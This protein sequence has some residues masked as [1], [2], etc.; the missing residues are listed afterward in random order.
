[1]LRKLRKAHAGLLAGLFS[2]ALMAGCASAPVEEST[3]FYDYDPES[4]LLTGTLDHAVRPLALQAVVTPPEQTAYPTVIVK[5]PVLS[6][7]EID[8]WIQAFFGDSGAQAEVAG[9]S[10][11]VDDSDT[12]HC[13]ATP[14]GQSFSYSEYD[15]RLGYF[16]IGTSLTRELGLKQYTVQEEPDTQALAD[17]QDAA[18]ALLEELGLTEFVL[19]ST[20]ALAL[21]SGPVCYALLYSHEIAGL[22]TTYDSYPIPGTYQYYNGDN[23]YI[24]VI[25]GAVVYLTGFIREVVEVEVSRE[26]IG[27]EAAMGALEKNSAYISLT[28]DVDI[29]IENISLRYAPA[30]APLEEDSGAYRLYPAWHFGPKYTNVYSTGQNLLDINAYDGSVLG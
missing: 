26:I 25:D 4:G 5:P 16:H 14:D 28:T 9:Q 6:D 10:P 1:M 27:L 22:P 8:H 3:R 19:D 24:I 7:Q 13:F 29:P 11:Y 23:L 2:L 12:F 18:A 17:A 30:L 15:G 21:E 20:E